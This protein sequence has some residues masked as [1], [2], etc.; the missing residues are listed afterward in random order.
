MFSEIKQ[1]AQYCVNQFPIPIY[2]L[3]WYMQKIYKKVWREINIYDVS[4]NVLLFKL[5]KNFV[6]NKYALV[7]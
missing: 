6:C 2:V 5:F 7:P 3:Y 1:S 4:P